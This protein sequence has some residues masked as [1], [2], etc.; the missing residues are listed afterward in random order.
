M[1]ESSYPL[2]VAQTITK[3]FY[4]PNIIQIL[5]EISLEIA[6]GES[7]AIVGRSGEG[8]STLLQILG[9]LEDPCGGELYIAGEKVISSNRTRLRNEKIGF[10]FQSFHLLEDYTAL[11]N[12]L[13]PARIARQPIGKGSKAEKRALF[14]LEKVGLSDRAHFHTKL[15]SGGEK[16]RVALARAMCN[17]PCLILADEPTGNLDSQTA[18]LIHEILINFAQNPSKALLLVTHDRELAGL[19]SRQYELHN[20]ILYHFGEINPHLSASKPRDSTIVTG[21]ISNRY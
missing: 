15:L 18:Q 14:L 20:G 19:C 9:T 21:L 6:A 8:K 16:Q 10:I 12:I 5:K 11:E 2:L 17:D 4:Y 3:S 7:V 13:M 1:V